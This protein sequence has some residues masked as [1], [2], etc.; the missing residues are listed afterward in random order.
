MDVIV[1]SAGA[2]AASGP[3]ALIALIATGVTLLALAALHVTSPGLQPSWRMVSEYAN[4]PT[5]GLLLVF[6]LAWSVSSVALLVALAPH[7]SGWMGILGLGLLVLAAVGQAMGGIFDINHKLHGLAAMIGIPTLCI[8][9]ILLT[10]SLARNPG[11][12]APPLWLAVLPLIS[13]VLMIVALITFFSALKA[14]GIEMS[15]NAAPLKEL[16]EGVT[17]YVGWANRALV[18][19]AC[20]WVA[21]AALNVIRAQP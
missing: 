12:S 21:M 17:G 14:A 4:G 5:P 15:P 18:L 16:P 11:I 19:T 3:A 10:L 6:F 8:A 7:V 13:F 1:N 20:L 9:A 2:Q